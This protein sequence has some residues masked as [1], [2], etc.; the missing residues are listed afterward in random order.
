MLSTTDP[1]TN[2]APTFVGNGYLAARVPAA[3]E[4]YSNSPIV[5]QSE[6]AGDRKSVV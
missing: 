4:G 1:S 3:G 6:L 5:T 2:Y